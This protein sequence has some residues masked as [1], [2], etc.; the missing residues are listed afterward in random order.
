MN[1]KEAVMLKA[2]LAGSIAVLLLTTGVAAQLGDEKP[3]HDKR[4][5][6]ILDEKEI[7]YVIDSDGDFKVT[8]DMGDDRSQVAFIRS[9]TN[10]YGKFEIREIWA[11]GYRSPSDNGAFPA[12]VANRMLEDTFS[13]K[14][15]AWAKMGE[16]AVYVVKISANTDAESLMAALTFA[17]EAADEMEE[18]LTGDKDEF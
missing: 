12:S 10:T 6:K 9:S 16:L 11:I 2:A 15:G 3:E 5:Q 18:E 7:K 4:I 13:K 17:L 8:F 1:R 14:L